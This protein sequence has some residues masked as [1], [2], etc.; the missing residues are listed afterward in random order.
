MEL[1]KILDEKHFF[2][3]ISS[4]Y[5]SN[6]NYIITT[7]DDLE[8]DKKYILNCLKNKSLI[9]EYLLNSLEYDDLSFEGFGEEDQRIEIRA[10]ADNLIY[11]DFNTMKFEC[12]GNRDYYIEKVPYAFKVSHLLNN[13]LD[14]YISW[15]KGTNRLIK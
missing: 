12:H 6:M 11:F 9:N 2:C 7:A 15:C 10:C 1:D 8:I 4:C 14:E 13:E 5:K 3:T